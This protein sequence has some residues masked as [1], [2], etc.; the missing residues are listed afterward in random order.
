MQTKINVE[1]IEELSKNTNTLLTN[2]YSNYLYYRH[3]G[4][5]NTYCFIKHVSHI[6][7]VLKFTLLFAMEN[8]VL[9]QHSH[10]KNIF[11]IH[12]LNK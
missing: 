4:F 12:E 7:G 8:H 2:R 3:G 9:L 11:N 6:T 1:D 10:C 5:T